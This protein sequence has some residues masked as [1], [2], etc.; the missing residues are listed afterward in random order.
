MNL[1]VRKR[2]LGVSQRCVIQRDQCEGL[3]GWVL[4]AGYKQ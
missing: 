2:C 3:Q 4:Q 1:G